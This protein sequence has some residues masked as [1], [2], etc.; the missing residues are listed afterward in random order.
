MDAASP[1][2]YDDEFDVGSASAG[3]GPTT[4]DASLSALKDNIKRK[5]N[6][7]YVSLM[8][9]Q[10]SACCDVLSSLFIIP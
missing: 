2:T 3:S 8:P 6:N 1:S 4:I 7:R 9:R 10:Q 5:G